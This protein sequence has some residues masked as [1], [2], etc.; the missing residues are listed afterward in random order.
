[1][2]ERVALLDGNLTI[3]SAPGSGATIFARI[4]LPDTA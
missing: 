4:P 3:E 2:Q 1:M